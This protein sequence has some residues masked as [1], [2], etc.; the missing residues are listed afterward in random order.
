MRSELE[1]FNSY[2][3]IIIPPFFLDGEF[4]QPLQNALGKVRHS[5]PAGVS[6]I[7]NDL[8]GGLMGE[9]GNGAVSMCLG[10]RLQSIS[11]NFPGRGLEI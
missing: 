6:D 4:H 5:R 7:L 3:R 8:A 2:N 9:Q 10:K 1:R 11:V